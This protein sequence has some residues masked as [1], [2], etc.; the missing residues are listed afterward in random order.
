MKQLMLIRHA[1]ALHQYVK[2]DFERQLSPKGI[3]EAIEMAD[4]VKEAGIKPQLIVTS[5]AARAES[6]AQIFA[7]RLGLPAPTT[8]GVIY[9]G[10]QND[11]LKIINELPA[12][13]DCIA[14]VGHNPDISNLLYLLTGDLKDV[15]T[16]TVVL[17]SFEFDDWQL[18]SGGTGTIKWYGSPA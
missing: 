13:K 17:I 11:L 9:A 16:A 2:G 3:N 7:E 1:N 12:K 8:N 5:E 6:T 14:L 18:I 10:D 15:P 4:R